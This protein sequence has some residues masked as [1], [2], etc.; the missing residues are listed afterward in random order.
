MSGERANKALRQLMD[1]RIPVVVFNGVVKSVSGFTC[2]VEPIDGGPVYYSV[3]LRVSQNDSDTGV[4]Q[5]PNQGSDCVVARLGANENNLYLISAE[6]V[7]EYV[8]KV[9]GGA[10]IRVGQNGITSINGEQYGGLVVAQEL[11]TELAKVN[12]YLT[13]L[14][15]AIQAAPVSP[16]DGGAAFK[17]S[18][19]SALSSM[20]I[21]TY[22]NIE[23]TKTKHGSL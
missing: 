1:R 19:A 5:I 21:P 17:A 20:Q 2:D 9:A 10:E 23:S 4:Y 18:L 13:T 3:R 11:R 8:I 7:K 14:R 22:T 15:S 6:D 16:G 12:T